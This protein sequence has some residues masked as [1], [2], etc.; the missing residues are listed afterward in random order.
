[1]SVVNRCRC[2][3]L[4]AASLV[5]VVRELVHASCPVL[6]KDARVP[7]LLMHLTS[8]LNNAVCGA[9]VVVL[10]LHLLEVIVR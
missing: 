9:L 2:S 8:I 4:A 3:S 1:M 6:A 7:L 10:S 5:A